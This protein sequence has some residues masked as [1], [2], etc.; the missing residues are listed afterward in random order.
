MTA[1]R[2]LYP[3]I[4]A[5]ALYA[6]PLSWAQRPAAGAPKDKPRQ[7]SLENKPWKGDF[8]QMLERRVIR[9]LAPYSRSLFFNDKGRERGLA[10]ELVRDFERYVNQKYA[11]QLGKRPVTVFIIATTRDK[12]LTN[13]NEGLGD[14]SA[15]R[16]RSAGSIRTGGSTTWRS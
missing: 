13:L 1:S 2:L 11:K 6:A 16:P 15:G 14:I 8:D 12:L 4:A 3:L 5:L 7:L 9:V 10:A